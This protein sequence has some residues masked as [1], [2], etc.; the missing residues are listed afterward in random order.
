MHNQYVMNGH[1][2]PN[3]WRNLGYAD[4]VAYLICLLDGCYAGR[5][6]EISTFIEPKR[7]IWNV[8]TS[9]KEIKQHFADQKKLE[10]EV[11]SF[12]VKPQSGL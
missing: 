5:V 12:S 10:S 11:E 7:T 3:N 2:F 9:F 6:G 4:S 8:W 1:K